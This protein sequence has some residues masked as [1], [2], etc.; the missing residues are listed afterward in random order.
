[1]KSLEKEI[2]SVDDICW[3]NTE[4]IIESKTVTNLLKFLMFSTFVI[5]R[6]IYFGINEYERWYK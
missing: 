1:M 2:I 6:Q 5:R 3:N 4:D